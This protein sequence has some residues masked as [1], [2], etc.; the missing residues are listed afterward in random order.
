M[1][2]LR[3]GVLLAVLLGG[4]A[5]AYV[6]TRPAPVTATPRWVEDADATPTPSAL[7]SAMPSATPSAVIS[8]TPTVK[9][10]LL[11]PGPVTINTPGFWSWALINTRT[12]QVSGAKNLA[13]TSTT[14]SMV[15]AW[16]AA[17]YLRRAAE[18]GVTPDTAR[19]N[20]LSI[21]IRDSDNN[22]AQ[23]IYELLGQTASIKRL[24]SK[25]KLTDSSAVSG[26][27]SR[28]TVSARDT[29]RMAA[30]IGD[31][32]AAGP[33]WTSWLLNEMR[34]VRGTGDF[35]IRKALPAEI[36]KQTAIKNGWLLRD[37]DGLWH[38]A[39]LAI[40]AGWTL[41]VLVRY[42]GSLGF[43]HGANICKSVAAQLM[44]G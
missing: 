39:C 9:L 41:G 11:R 16:L 2:K 37:T 1:L 23:D 27:W 40:G 10:P 6:V 30:C 36:A 21:M 20:E 4:V 24:I 29:A 42:P 15:K 44:H 35:G 19:I 43:E 3:V 12:G 18:Q 32:R 13:A 25:C 7:P 14:A 8:P 38:M 26:S 34:H 22:A 17:D 33:K 28:T 31:G 5:S